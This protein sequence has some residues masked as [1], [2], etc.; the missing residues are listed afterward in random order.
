MRLAPNHPHYNVWKE[1]ITALAQDIDVTL[2]CCGTKCE[3]PAWNPGKDYTLK[4]PC[5]GWFIDS[6]FQVTQGDGPFSTEQQAVEHLLDKT[7]H[8]GRCPPQGPY[9]LWKSAMLRAMSGENVHI[10]YYGNSLECP[11]WGGDATAYRVEKHAFYINEVDFTVQSHKH[12]AMSRAYATADEAQHAVNSAVSV[13][14]RPPEGSCHVAIWREAMQRYI[15]G[16]KIRLHTSMTWLSGPPDWTAQKY[17]ICR[18]SPAKK[19]YFDNAF[20]IRLWDSLYLHPEAKFST[21]QEAEAY[22]TEKA[23][24]LGHDPHLGTVWLQAMHAAIHEGRDVMVQ[25]LASG[26]WED[27]CIPTWNLT[28][29]YRIVPARWSIDRATFEPVRKSD[30]KFDTKKDAQAWLDDQTPKPDN[31]HLGLWKEYITLLI[32]GKEPVLEY[33]QRAGPWVERLRKDVMLEGV[34]YRL[35]RSIDP[36]KLY[37]VVGISDV[38]QTLGQYLM[39]KAFELGCVFDTEE[40][41]QKRVQSLQNWMRSTA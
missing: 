15:S 5:K 22:K 25:K 36:K 7:S 31:R 8:L 3:N 10:T 6:D 4:Y 12:E 35:K 38:Y 41:A 40:E 34:E 28:A 14:G 29:Y 20:G 30:G 33:K 13:L 26:V 9:D 2:Y 23:G 19:Y 1:Y 21:R 18:Y 37:W 32:D 16:E 11:T 24:H 27:C 17:V 39:P